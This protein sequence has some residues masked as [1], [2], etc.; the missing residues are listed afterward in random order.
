VTGK[1][2]A[3]RARVRSEIEGFLRIFLDRKLY[4]AP[5]SAARA[6]AVVPLALSLPSPRCT[7]SDPP[8]GAVARRCV[9]LLELP[10]LVQ[11]ERGEEPHEATVEITLA[12]DERGV[13]L[14]ATLGGPDLFVRYEETH[15]VKPI[16]PGDTAQRAAAVTR[17]VE[18]VS[19]VFAQ[20]VSD[21]PSCRRRP[22]PGTALELACSG[23]RVTVA[24]AKAAGEDDRVVIRPLL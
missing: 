6:E 3:D 10:F 20:A 4:E 14:E 18:E 12:Q 16:A 24:A 17:A 13:P 1:A 7:L 23:M 15:R 2:A 22:A 5:L 8:E 19:A 9:K 21:S 11:A